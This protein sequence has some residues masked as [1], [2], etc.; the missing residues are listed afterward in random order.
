MGGRKFARMVVSAAHAK[1]VVGR[2]CVH[3]IVNVLHARNV[4]E[5][6]SVHMGGLRLSVKTVAAL[7][8]APIIAYERCVKLVVDPRY[9]F[10]VDK[11]PGASNV[12]APKSVLTSVAEVVVENAVVRCTGIDLISVLCGVND[13]VLPIPLLIEVADS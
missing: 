8:S 11:T 3:T 1:T 2:R 5:A 7:R 9:V 6:R 12:E 10:M 4:E 13:V